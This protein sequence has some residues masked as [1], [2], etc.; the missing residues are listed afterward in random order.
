MKS[1]FITLL[2]I[3]CCYHAVSQDGLKMPDDKEK[4]VIPFKMINNLIFIPLKINGI[5]LYFM[6][7]SGSETTILFSLDE[8]NDVKF[9]DVEKIKLKGYGND[10]FVDGLKSSNNNLIC[11]GLEDNH[12]TVYIVLDQEFNLS[13][14]V[15]FPVNGI[16]GYHFFKNYLVETN[17]TKKK[18]IVYKDNSKI[19]KKLDKKFS[20]SDLDFEN[21]KPYFRQKIRIDKKE[22]Y[23][24]LLIDSGSSDA[25]WLFEN[26]DNNLKVPA[27]NFDDCL[28]RGFSG[29]IYGK[30]ARINH[31]SINEFEFKNPLVAFPDSL[32]VQNSVI[33]FGREGSVGAEILKR[34]RIIYDYPNSKIYFKKNGFY[35]NPFNFNMSG[36]DVQ[37]DGLK[38][39]QEKV[40]LNKSGQKSI[41]FD[42]NTENIIDF[43]YEFK[44]KPT[45]KIFNIR[46][47][48]P[49]EKCGLLVDDIIISINNTQLFNYTLQQINDLLKSEDG[50]TIKIEVER[51]GKILNY[52]FI[53]EEML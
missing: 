29:S 9:K 19:K 23:V 1:K 15:G 40:D 31:F 51:A 44:L 38:W 32:A 35:Y 17:Y 22:V 7:D 8:I 11:N 49:A 33:S 21:N 45:F 4:I 6:L 30:R 36:I 48:S 50:K 10:N 27:K 20:F 43:R 16:I 3:F 46:K 14:M 26:Q 47:N 28:G 25:L 34:F 24:K 5:E 37:H 39:V 42:V 18:I 2:I 52:K 53:L 12:H 13:P 41:S